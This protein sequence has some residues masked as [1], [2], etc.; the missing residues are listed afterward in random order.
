MNKQSRFPYA[1][2]DKK[3]PKKPLIS[4]DEKLDEALEETF[5]ASD[6][7]AMTEPTE[8]VV[9]DK[10][11]IQNPPEPPKDEKPKA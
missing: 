4:D 11:P 5:P 6:P 10:E 8:H 9:E 1:D 7:P 2:D 3:N